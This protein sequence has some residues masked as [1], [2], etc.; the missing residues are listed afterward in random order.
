MDL[1]ITMIFLINRLK[2]DRSTYRRYFS[3]DTLRESVSHDQTV[4]HEKVKLTE[5]R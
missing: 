4:Q 2:E 5:T 1:D 3:P